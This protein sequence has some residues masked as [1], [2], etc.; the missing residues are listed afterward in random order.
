MRKTS[1]DAA[2]TLA[3]GESPSAMGEREMEDLPHA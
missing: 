3:A 2:R 1:H